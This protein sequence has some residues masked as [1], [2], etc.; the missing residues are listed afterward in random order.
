MNQHLKLRILGG[1]SAALLFFAAVFAGTFFLTEWLFQALDQRPTPFVAQTTTSVLGL[2][3]GAVI[4]TVIS[5]VVQRS[6]LKN[7]Q[8]IFRPIV[9]AL[10]R[11]AAGDFSVRLSGTM[12]GHEMVSDLIESVNKLALELGQIERMRREFVSNVSHEIQSP[13][14]SIRGFARALQDESLDPA[15]R[16]HY[17][18]IIET[19]S[20]RLSRLSDNLLRLASLEAEQVT[21]ERKPFRVDKQIRDLLLASEPQWTAKHLDLD[22]S[23][24]ELTIPGDEALL[25]QVWQNLIH[26]SIRF[27]GDGGTVCLSLARQ[28]GSAEFRIADTGTGIP[29]EDLP[30]IFERFYKADKSRQR[31][32]G[33]SGLGLAI[34]YKIVAMHQGTIGVES[35]P[36]RGATFCVRLPVS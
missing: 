26:N 12:L 24:D 4:L 8:R 20:T 18:T 36:G 7:R 17:L 13:L 30:H 21:F 1:M 19:E 33:G 31:S 23:L 15:E 14:T 28:N 5:S 3:L 32:E 34:A 10:E 11:I 35:A 27:S 2:V 6:Q 16:R 9:D 25:G 29:A 22:V